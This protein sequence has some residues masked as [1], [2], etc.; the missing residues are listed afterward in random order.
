MQSKCLFNEKFDL[1]DCYG[2]MK[3]NSR[4]K[5]KFVAQGIGF[6]AIMFGRKEEEG[7]LLNV[8][9]SSSLVMF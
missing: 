5:M 6:F 4:K 2:S 7:Q 1:F 9:R 3:D 8:A